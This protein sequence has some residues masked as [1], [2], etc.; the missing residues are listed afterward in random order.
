MAF[1]QL[2][3]ELRAKIWSL[4]R[5]RHFDA[6]LGAHLAR[7][8]AARFVAPKRGVQLARLE[9]S[10]TKLMHLGWTGQE[11][12][13]QAVFET[14]ESG[15]LV[16]RWWLDRWGWKPTI[17][18]GRNF[19]SI[20]TPDPDVKIVGFEGIDQLPA[21]H[22]RNSSPPPLLHN[23]AES[24]VAWWNNYNDWLEATGYT[25]HEDMMPW[26]ARHVVHCCCRHNFV[27]GLMEACSPQETWS[28]ATTLHIN[29]GRNSC[30][31][32]PEAMFPVF[33]DLP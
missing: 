12:I 5:R 6:Q 27:K 23:T 30:A 7:K 31:A 4:A 14:V 24:Y 22:V 32:D 8:K 26:Y 33:K 25:R 1:F 17:W 21:G 29:L 10:P 9:I 18:G 28:T 20:R 15:Y 2:P 19:D 3:D 11:E 13:D 16:D